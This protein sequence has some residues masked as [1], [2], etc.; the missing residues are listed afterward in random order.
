MVITYPHRIRLRGPW[1]YQVMPDG[2]TGRVVMPTS[3]GSFRGTMRLQRRFGYPGQID[4][5]ERVWLTLAGYSRSAQITLNEIVL[6]SGQ[7]GDQPLEFDVT[8]LLRMRN[9][10]EIELT[11]E[12]EGG[13]WGE[14]ALEVR[15]LAFLRDVK[16]AVLQQQGEPRLHITG[17]C[18][19]P[20]AS[21]FDLYAVMNRR[22][23]AYLSI[24]A[25]PEGQ[26]FLLVTEE[27]AAECW[28]P[29]APGEALWVRIDLV[30]GAG[31]WYTISRE[32]P[33]PPAG[34]VE[35]KG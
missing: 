26:P 30:K 6:A 3:W 24:P 13:L 11:G 5:D 19:G 22:P 32:L 12:E 23:V 31:V 27:T 9:G 10:L 15:C 29:E 21:F 25:A 7:A 35:V 16:V 20:D 14:V 8:G 28:E 18:I 33:R 2:P 17:K 4:E 34:Y 1:T